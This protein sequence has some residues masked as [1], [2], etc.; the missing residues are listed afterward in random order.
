[1]RALRAPVLAMTAMMA[2]M[3]AASAD[4]TFEQVMAA[5][6][7]VNLDVAYAKAEA[8]EGHLL[9]AAAALE[10]VLM[11]EPNAASARLFYA[12]VLYRL[13]DLQAANAQLAL[14]DGAQLPPL[15]RKELEKYRR[16]VSGSRKTTTFNGELAAGIAYDSDALG[17][18][19]IGT[20][21][22]GSKPSHKPG[23]GAVVSAALGG[24]TR[25]DDAYS[26]YAALAGYSRTDFSDSEAQMQYFGGE[27]GLKNTEQMTSWQIAGV[28]RHTMLFGDPLL[29]EYGGRASFDWR[30]DTAVT[31]SASF[32]GV[33]QDYHEPFYNLFNNPV[34]HNADD[35]AYYRMQG[36]LAWRIDSHS[37]VDLSVGYETHDA[38]YKP[39]G[40]DAPFANVDYRGLLGSG[41]YVDL[42]GNLRWV[43]YQAVDTQ[44]TGVRRNDTDYLVRAALGVPLSAFS[45]DGATGDTLEDLTLEGS[46]NYASSARTAPFSD[47]GGFGAGLRLVWHFGDGR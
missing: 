6:D 46:V 11:L 7:D 18:L 17:A 16:V 31:L 43:R 19:L 29:T 40:Y 28:A 10:R 5:P 34:V 36:G 35:G 23:T 26:L 12:V 1:M 15:E 4:P 33:W 20:P 3:S 32:E 24:S 21:L 47:Y 30:A 13:D 27:I 44:F 14:V 25:L 37:R 22:G 2:A 38:S 42:L 45:A 39:F 8:N 9:S 41:V